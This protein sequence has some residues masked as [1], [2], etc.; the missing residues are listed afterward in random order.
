VIHGRPRIRGFLDQLVDLAE[1]LTIGQRTML[2][3][4]D[5]ALGQESWNMLFGK[6]EAAVRRTSRSTIVL[7]RIEGAWRIAVVDPWRS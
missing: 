5:V 7:A 1:D 4:G 6:G 2:T 3:A